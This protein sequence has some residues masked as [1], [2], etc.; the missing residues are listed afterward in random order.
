MMAASD[1]PIHTALRTPLAR[2]LSYTA[3]RKSESVLR[4]VVSRTVTPLVGGEDCDLAAICAGFPM[5]FTGTLMGLPESDWQ[6]L[7]KLT[8]MAIA[9]QEPEFRAGSAQANLRAAHQQLFE[10]FADQLSHPADRDDLIG[11]MR[12]MTIDGR[13]MRRDELIYNCYSLLLGANVT[14]PHAIAAT[15]LAFMEHEEEYQRIRTGKEVALAVEEGLRWSSPANHFMRH[16]V[17]DTELSGVPIAAGQAVVAWLGSANR[18]DRVFSQPF[19]FDCTRRPNRHLAFGAGPHYC[20]GAPL[21]RVALRLLFGQLVDLVEGFDAGGPVLHLRSNFVAGITHMP[22]VARPRKRM[23]AT[24]SA[25]P[26]GW[27]R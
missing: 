1:P 21:A 17:H 24:R 10:Y 14:T 12:A 6:F 11:F 4:S 22:I 18:D 3:L 20:V 26:D 15:V 2:A 19:S 9:P 5:A 13:K 25:R 23:Q 27:T 8:T 7:T 16:A